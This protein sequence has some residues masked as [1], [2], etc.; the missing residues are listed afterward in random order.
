MSIFENLPVSLTQE[1]VLNTP[2]AT[3]SRDQILQASGL[4]IASIILLI[5]LVLP[6]YTILSKSVEDQQGGFI[7]LANYIDYFS[8]PALSMSISHTLTIAFITTFIVIGLALLTAYALTRTCMPGRGFFKVFLMAPIFAPSLLPA[9]SLVYL[10]GNQGVLKGLMFGETIYGPIGIVIGLAFWCFPH[11]LMILVTA[12]SN[13]D[14]RLYESAKVLRTSGFRTFMTITLPSI[15]YGLISASFVVFTLVITDFGVPK[16]IGG[17]Y[18]MLA[19]DIYKQV[20]GQQN[21]SMGAV[22]SVVLLLPAL[23]AFAIDRWVQRKQVALLS[24]RAAP[25]IPKK[26]P[27]KDWTMLALCLPVPIIIL[28]VLG[29]AVYASLVSFWPYNLSLSFANYQ[30]DLMDGGGWE[31]YYN[32]LEMACWTALIGTLFIFYNAYL[33]EKIKGLKTLRMLYHLAAMIPL[34]VPGMVLGLAYV[35]FFNA[36]N[37]PLNFV[38]GTMAILVICTVAHYYTVCHLTAVTALKQIDNEFEAVSASLKIPFY[39]TFWRVIMPV[40]L[41]ALLEIGSYLFMNAMTTVSAVVFIYSADTMLASVAVLN[42]DDAGDI[43]PAAAMGV[44]IMGTCILAKLIHWVFSHYL[45][46][47]TQRWRADT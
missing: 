4:L 8:T 19:T 21:F 25:L 29:M 23:F 1:T 14:A 46:A 27:V 44:L 17:Q 16:V 32:S 35:F 28:T 11:A 30:F 37:N 10:F 41:P 5:T 26:N 9:I 2:K 13:T 47:R 40:S 3:L 15:K 31:A 12:L 39:V 38:Y 42:M 20:I 22:V 45:L 43:A 34:A 24:A 36:P 6:L 7:G 18:N 33:V